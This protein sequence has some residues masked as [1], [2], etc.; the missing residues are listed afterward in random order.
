M[1]HQLTSEHVGCIPMVALKSALVAFNLMATAYPWV[2]SPAL[3]PTI[4]NPITRSCKN[5]IEYRCRQSA[6][7]TGCKLILVHRQTYHIYT[8]ITL[9]KT[10]TDIKAR[11]NKSSARTC[12]CSCNFDSYWPLQ[13]SPWLS[14]LH[15][16]IA[17]CTSAYLPHC[18]L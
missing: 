5:K 18:R 1:W 14:R 3:G 12:K 4:W 13:R 10:K 8:L 2:I 11:Q 7:S 15:H 16:G 9:L 17:K 6:Y